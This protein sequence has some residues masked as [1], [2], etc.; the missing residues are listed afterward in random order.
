MSIAVPLLLLAGWQSAIHFDWWPRTLIAAPLDVLV[1]LGKLTWSG[2]LLA[3]ARVSLYRLVGGFFLGTGL[4]VVLGSLVGLSK[5]AERMVAPTIQALSPVPPTAWI[6][7]VIILFGIEELSKTVLI[8]IG[9]FTVVYFSTVQG[10]RGADQKLVEVAATLQKPR[11]DLIFYVLLPS[12]AP[13]ILTGMRVAL[14]LSWILLIAAEMIGAKMVSASTRQEGLGLGWLIY[15]ARNFSRPDD[16][17]VGMIAIGL[18]GKSSDMLMAWLERTVL[19]WR[20][21]FK[22]I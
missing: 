21:A 14:G 2:E 16:M 6:P 22:G 15:D 11:R 5:S 19:Q 17:I 18:L 4:A 8:S 20:E 1:D 7:L 10:I 12:A 9:A 13:S 3:H